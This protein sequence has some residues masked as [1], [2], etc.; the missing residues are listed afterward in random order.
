M[1]GWVQ[2][3]RLTRSERRLLPGQGV[4]E[5]QTVVARVLSLEQPDRLICHAVLGNRGRVI[6]RI[7]DRIG[8]AYPSVPFLDK[9][10]RSRPVTCLTSRHNL[11]LV[12]DDHP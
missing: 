11:T 5:C 9:P 1:C 7:D 3:P 6:R 12:T 8:P 2:F 4:H 10:L